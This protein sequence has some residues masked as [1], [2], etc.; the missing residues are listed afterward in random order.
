MNLFLVHD[1]GLNVELAEKVRMTTVTFKCD[2][3][4]FEEK[5]GESCVKVD[6]LKPLVLI[7]EYPVQWRERPKVD[8]SELARLRWVE[9]WTALCIQ[10][11][12]GCN[13]STV[14]K[15]L[16]LLRIKQ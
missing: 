1:A 9:K 11:H 12:F 16:K 2:R 8:L 14:F 15:K 3:R 7:R 13:R 10:E 6:E 4:F 5:N